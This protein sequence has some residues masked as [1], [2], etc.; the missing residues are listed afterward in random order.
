MT[1]SPSMANKGPSS[2]NLIVASP[3]L[4]RDMREMSHSSASANTFCPTFASLR[5]IKFSMLRDI[6]DSDIYDASM[7]TANKKAP[8]SRGKAVQARSEEIDLLN[9][10]MRPADAVL[11]MT[12][13]RDRCFRRLFYAYHSVF[14]RWLAE[15]YP[16]NVRFQTAIT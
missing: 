11:A 16:I 9:M 10:V 7:D 5:K 6:A 1:V 3:L 14:L 13:V 12:V 15:K 2:A 4:K 8:A